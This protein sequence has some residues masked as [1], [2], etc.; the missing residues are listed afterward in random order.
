MIISGTDLSVDARG[1]SKNIMQGDAFSFS[2]QVDN[3]GKEKAKAVKV[4][5][6]TTTDITGAKESFIGNIDPDDSSAAVFDLTVSPGAAVGA[7]PVKIIV[8]YFDEND[9]NQATVHEFVF[10]VNQRPAESPVLLIV[11]LIILL[12]VLYFVLR[13]VFRQLSL[14]KAKLQ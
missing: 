6:D 9:S 2:V 3:I 12:G 13:F 11:L 10:F 4:L 7:N 14:R 8:E 5:L 1:D